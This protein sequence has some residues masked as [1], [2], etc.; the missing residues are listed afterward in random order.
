MIPP[1]PP[2][3]VDLPWPP[4]AGIVL[5]TVLLVGVLRSQVHGPADPG[6]PANVNEV[7]PAEPPWG[8]GSLLPRSV[9]QGRRRAAIQVEERGG[10]G[11]RGGL[12]EAWNAKSIL[13]IDRDGD[14][15]IC[16]V[17][18]HRRWAAAVF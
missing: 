18:D 1:P 10:V 7:A 13:F 11:E 8:D 6:A 14:A 12:A 15:S 17:T 9:L 2:P 4:S 16:A 3:P 5:P